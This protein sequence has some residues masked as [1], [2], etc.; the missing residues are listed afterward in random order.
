M[1]RT[2]NALLLSAGLCS[3]P[4][5]CFSATVYDNSATADP[6]GGQYFPNPATLEFGD[7][8][9]LTGAERTVSQFSF[10]RFLS[11]AAGG[12][13]TAT[14]RFYANNGTNAPTTPFYTS[15]PI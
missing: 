13:Q 8:I 5:L 7:Q 6:S 12:G 9:T 10:Y 1:N 15:D 4:N 2:L 14:I 3:L 11:G